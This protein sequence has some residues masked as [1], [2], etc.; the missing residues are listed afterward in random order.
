M[1]NTSN[2]EVLSQ[3][4]QAM[5]VMVQQ[6]AAILAALNGQPANHPVNTTP[7]T[8][9][10]SP[11]AKAEEKPATAATPWT[12]AQI[13]RAEKVLINTLS[14]KDWVVY[15]SAKRAAFGTTFNKVKGN[16]VKGDPQWTAAIE[17]G[18]AAQID[19][20]PGLITAAANKAGIPLAK[21]V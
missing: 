3:L 5:G 21:L 17:A 19:E 13:K 14:A 12:A 16:A 7:T 15:G 9:A 6:N 8:Q 20:L 11:S 4:A 2:K 1:G 18:A 10:A